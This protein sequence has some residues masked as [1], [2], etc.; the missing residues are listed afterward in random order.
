MGTTFIPFRD[1][2]SLNAREH[3]VAPSCVMLRRPVAGTDEQRRFLLV[4]FYFV[5]GTV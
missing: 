2:S 3:K 4:H 5:A 1:V